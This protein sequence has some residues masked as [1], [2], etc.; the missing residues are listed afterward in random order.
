M[1]HNKLLLEYNNQ[2][3][4]GT[5]MNTPKADRKEECFKHKAASDVNKMDD[6]YIAK[7]ILKMYLKNKWCI[8]VSIYSGL[9]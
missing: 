7:S 5:I 4:H 1:S 9:Y 3:V 2:V 6:K 8:Y